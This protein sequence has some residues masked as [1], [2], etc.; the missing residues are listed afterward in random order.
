MMVRRQ[1]I[2]SQS[3]V[4][5]DR[6]R[7]SFAEARIKLFELVTSK[8]LSPESATFRYLY[9]LH[10]SVMRRQDMYEDMWKVFV[11]AVVRIKESTGDRQIQIEA[12]D[13]S[14]EVREVVLQTARAIELM[15]F[16][17]SRPLRWLAA[18]NSWSAGKADAKLERLFASKT[19]SRR[20]EKNS[21][22]DSQHSRGSDSSVAEVE[23]FRNL[24]L[25]V[26]S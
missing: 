26:A 17:H 21:M 11:Y 20:T 13:W 12:S 19:L 15:I 8:K 9:Y 6:I 25:S 14:S 2:Q 16:E 18:I 5:V 22:P 1:A 24:I 4:R 3:I 10:T 7:R 23:A